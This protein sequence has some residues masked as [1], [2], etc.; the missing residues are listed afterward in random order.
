M[1]FNDHSNLEGSHALLSASQYHWLRYDEDKL[2]E[3]VKKYRATVEGERLHLFAK[4]AILLK[5]KLGG[6]NT[7]LK[8]FVNDAIGFKM[9]PE[10]LLYYSPYCYGTTDA[11]M[12]NRRQAK[13]RIHDLKNGTSKASMDQLLV[14]AGLFFLEYGVKPQEVETELRIYQSGDILGHIPDY[15]ELLHIMDRIVWSDKVVDDFLDR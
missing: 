4:E 7:A 9:S 12:F 5:Q 8:M 15:D 6:P 11:I 3:K 14:Y 10:V 1:D 2:I 13:L